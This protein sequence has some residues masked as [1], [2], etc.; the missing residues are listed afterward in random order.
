M[1]SQTFVDLFPCSV[2]SSIRNL[3]RPKMHVDGL[4]LLDALGIHQGVFD[5]DLLALRR[6]KSLLRPDQYPYKVQVKD[7]F[8]QQPVWRSPLSVHR[9][10][11]GKG[12]SD[13]GKGKGKGKMVDVEVEEDVEPTENDIKLGSVPMRITSVEHG[14]TTISKALGWK[15]TLSPL[16]FNFD[17]HMA[18]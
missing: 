18:S 6:D 16:R 8:K 14:F 10:E 3:D 17:L 1:N 11:K 13:K 9:I 2:V 4:L 5:D 7:E 15:S 12:S